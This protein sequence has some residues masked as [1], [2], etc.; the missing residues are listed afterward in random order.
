MSSIFGLLHTTNTGRSASHPRQHFSAR[1]ISIH[2]DS[3]SR[4][5]YLTD[6]EGLAVERYRLLRRRLHTLHPDGG[7]VLMTSPS[8]GEGKTLTSVNLAWSF[9]EVGNSTCLVDLD[10]RSPGMSR[11]LRY[12]FEEGG[13]QEVLQGE[14][15]IDESI[16]QL[17][18]HPLYVLG[19]KK[20]LASPGHLFYSQSMQR[21]VSKLRSMFKW[22]L[23]DF[24][25]VIPM[26][27]ISEMIENIDGALL[28][29]R[30]N[31]TEKDMLN[32][33]IEAIGSKLWGVVANDC[34]I[35]GSA[36][37]GSYGQEK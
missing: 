2:P 27:D 30:T 10:F 37:Y 36:Y 4:L 16:H 28:V 34:A 14:V 5:V 3:T 33:A 15:E 22:V 29:V 20:R 13:V 6:P 32:P 12:P 1:Q 23:L 11:M 21:M 17:G 8:P 26:A 18:E 9:A 35:S 25:P 31:K 19:I 24:A 7:V